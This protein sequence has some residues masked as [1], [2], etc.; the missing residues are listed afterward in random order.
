MSIKSNGKA[1]FGGKVVLDVDPIV[2]SIDTLVDATVVLLVEDV[3][4]RGM[5]DHAVQALPKLR[6]DVRQETGTHVFVEEDPALTTIVGAHAA[7]GGDAHPH[8]LIIGRIDDNGMQAQAARARPPL[9][10]RGMIGKA[11]VQAPVDAI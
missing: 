4:L 2:A 11:F 5:L 10:A 9:L 6:V 1:K 7:N 3:G 8:T